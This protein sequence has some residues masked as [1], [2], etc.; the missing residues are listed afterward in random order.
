MKR[1]YKE[2]ILIF[3][4]LAILFTPYVSVQAETVN[5]IS[6]GDVSDS[7]LVYYGYIPQLPDVSDISYSSLPSSYDP[8][9]TLMTTPV[10]D[11][12]N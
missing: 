5:N 7:G 4:S 2:F 9:D 3:L 8:R 11:Q 6:I 12:L 10:K 1:N